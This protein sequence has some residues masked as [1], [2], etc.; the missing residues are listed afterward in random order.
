MHPHQQLIET[1]YSSFARLD[2]AGMIS[3]YHEEVFFYDPVFENLDAAEARAMWTML[4]KNAKDF[5]LTYSKVEAD[6]EYGSCEWVADY[7]FSATGRKVNNIIKA[8]FKF[9]EGKIIEHM[10]DFDLWRWSRQALG[11]K[12]LLLGWSGFVQRKVRKGAKG[13]L[14]KFMAKNTN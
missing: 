3:C 9:H 4:C 11:F 6:D 12:G 7:T 1:F 13:N 14:K 10:D 5:S 2:A 8:H